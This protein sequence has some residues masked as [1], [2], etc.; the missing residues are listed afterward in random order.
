MICDLLSCPPVAGHHS[1]SGCLSARARARMCGLNIRVRRVLFWYLK[2][3]IKFKTQ[4][5]F[6]KSR[7][8][9]PVA[10][11][12]TFTKKTDKIIIKTKQLSSPAGFCSFSISLQSRFGSTMIFYSHTRSI[13]S[14]HSYFWVL[15]CLRKQNI[16]PNNLKC[17]IFPNQ[18]HV[19][20]SQDIK[21]MSMTF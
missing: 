15:K 14:Q 19:N 9:F 12:C 7:F 21:K 1:L 16:S 6:V 18:R 2:T 20:V 10:P 13:E 4:I 5:D 11:F 17:N 8:E 3:Q